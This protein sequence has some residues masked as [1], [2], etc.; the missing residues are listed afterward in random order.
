MTSRAPLAQYFL[1]LPCQIV[2]NLTN[3]IKL[4]SHLNQD[5]LIPK[6]P[7]SP[8]DDEFRSFELRMKPFWSVEHPTLAQYLATLDLAPTDL[9]NQG[10]KDSNKKSHEVTDSYVKRAR[11]STSKLIELT[12]LLGSSN[13]ATKVGNLLH[14][15]NTC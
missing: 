11:E 7:G 15:I 12:G 8:Y 6:A 2:P 4:Y 5:R 3:F 14:P 10:A 1:I 9:S 13:A